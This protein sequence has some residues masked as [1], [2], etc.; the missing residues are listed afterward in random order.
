[1]KNIKYLLPIQVD[2]NNFLK[3]LPNKF[4]QSSESR[5]HTKFLVKSDSE[6][7]KKTLNK[8][9]KHSFLKFIPC[10]FTSG[11]CCKLEKSYDAIFIL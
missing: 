2:K 5:T 6:L 8:S 1:M 3:I 7:L 10:I 4:S 11:D 9:F